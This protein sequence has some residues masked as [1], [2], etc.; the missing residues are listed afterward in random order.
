MSGSL[1]VSGLL[2][3][4]LTDAEA[5]R[6]V[7]LT[8]GGLLLLGLALLVGTVWWWRATRPEHPVLGPLEVMSERRWLKL[9]ADERRKRIDAHRPAGV[10]PDD[11]HQPVMAQPDEVD[12]SVLVASIGAD[13]VGPVDLAQFDRLLGLVQGEGVIEP[14]GAPEI[15]AGLEAEIADAEPEAE[16]EPE[17]E[18]DVHEPVFEIVDDVVAD[19]VHDGAHDDAE[20]GDAID[21]LL[22]RTS[23]QD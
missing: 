1:A 7:F 12:L 18:L 11:A 6:R 5:T 8:A 17:V 3:Q 23:A 4:D 16:V 15:E 14:D 2:A 21:P 19:D 22:Q 9:P 13:P 10:I 20:T